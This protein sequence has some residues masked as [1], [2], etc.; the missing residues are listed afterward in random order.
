VPYQDILTEARGAVGLVRLNRPTVRNALCAAM[1]DEL[2]PALDEFEADGAIG[3]IVV[4]AVRSFKTL[5]LR[6]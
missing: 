2:R 1:I 5:Q 4:I 6:L 3:A